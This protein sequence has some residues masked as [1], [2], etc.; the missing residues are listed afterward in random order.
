MHHVVRGAPAR[1][2]RLGAQKTALAGKS[3]PGRLVIK[4]NQTT[5]HYSGGSSAT[6][7]PMQVDSF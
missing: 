5:E 2:L 4:S 7:P 6:S 1:A 3:R